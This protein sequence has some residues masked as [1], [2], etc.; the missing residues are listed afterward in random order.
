M[1]RSPHAYRKLPGRRFGI[2]FTST[3]WIGPDHLLSVRKGRFAEEYR[4]FYFSDIQAIVLQKA[5]REFLRQAILF[6]PV[7]AAVAILLG[8]DARW[9]WLGIPAAFT[10]AILIP[11]L[12]AG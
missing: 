9:Y 5:R 12:A 2:L 8:T 4:R 6:L 7:L 1:P 11:W 3:L 10:L